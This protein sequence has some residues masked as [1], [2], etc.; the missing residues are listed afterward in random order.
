MYKGYTRFV[1]GMFEGCAE[2]VYTEQRVCMVCGKKCER[3]VQK[4][5]KRCPRDAQ[6]I[7][8]Q[9]NRCAWEEQRDVQGTHERCIWGVQG[10]CKR[11]TKKV[12]LM[13]KYCTRN[14]RRTH[15]RSL[16]CPWSWKPDNAPDLPG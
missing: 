6:S 15:R 12:S 11:Y 10:F 4:L 9:Y 8:V 7:Y 2:H 13:Y 16:G 14:V 5:Y 1:Q 3:D